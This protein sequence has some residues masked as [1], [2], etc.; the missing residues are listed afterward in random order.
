MDHAC[1]YKTK[2]PRLYWTSIR[3]RSRDDGGRAKG[4][5]SEKQLH[6]DCRS[7]KDVVEGMGK[8]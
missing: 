5:K 2:L 1:T 8:R 4:Q 7:V 6:F 3:D